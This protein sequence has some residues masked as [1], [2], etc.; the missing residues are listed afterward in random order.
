MFILQN[1]KKNCPE[2]CSCS[3]PKV[4]LTN[5]DSNDLEPVIEVNC[6]N[7][8]LVSVPENLLEKTRIIHLEDNEI[9]NLHLLK[10]NSVYKKVFEI[11]LD[12]NKIKSIDELE[13]SYFLKHFRVF[14]LKG[15]KLSEIPTYAI[16]NALAHN[17]N[18]PA[19]LKLTLGGNPWRCD[20]VFTPVFQV[21][22]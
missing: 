22:N 15:N 16:D 3:L 6:S 8:G 10:K 11:Y 13:G 7:R 1:I 4:I 20:C 18:M 19:A 5:I 2:P 17:E 14:S 12:K 21:P 9:E